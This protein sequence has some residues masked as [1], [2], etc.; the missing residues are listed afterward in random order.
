MYKRKVECHEQSI[1]YKTAKRATV[2][3]VTADK[4]WVNHIGGWGIT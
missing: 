3:S 1:L 2:L 4:M